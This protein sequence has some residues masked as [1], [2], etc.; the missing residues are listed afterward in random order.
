L[1][2]KPK[3]QWRAKLLILLGGMISGPLV[4]LALGFAG[5]IV[6]SIALQEGVPLGRAERRAWGFLVFVIWAAAVLLA[7]LP[8]LGLGLI[9][10]RM[11]KYLKVRCGKCGWSASFMLSGRPKVSPGGDELTSAPEFDAESGA[12]ADRPRS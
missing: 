2:P 1:A 12:A 3:W 7:L 4:I 8:A 9:A 10:A 5:E 11:P 6:G